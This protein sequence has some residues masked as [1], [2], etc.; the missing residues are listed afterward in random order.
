MILNENYE[1]L[2]VNIKGNLNTL[3]ETAFLD[4]INKDIS[5]S[6]WFITWSSNRF[7]YFNKIIGKPT[8]KNKWGN[9]K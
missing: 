9:T 8:G 2:L 3:R 7:G 4:K 6:Y 1:M 5:S